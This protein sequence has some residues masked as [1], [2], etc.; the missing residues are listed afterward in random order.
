MQKVFD[1][2]RDL[3]IEKS[4][5]FR[6]LGCLTSHP[7]EEKSPDNRYCS[8]C[9]DALS[10]EAESYS[11]RESWMPIKPA[12]KKVIPD[13]VLEDLVKRHWP[14]EVITAKLVADGYFVTVADVKMLIKV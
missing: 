3:L 13:V 5:G 1:Y 12:K 9:Y 8:F 2:E 6:C 11:R 14:V 10:K 4:G 7:A